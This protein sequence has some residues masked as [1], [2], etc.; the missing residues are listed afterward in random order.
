MIAVETN[1]FSLTV[2]RVAAGGNTGD[3]KYFYSFSP[4]I[5]LVREACL[6][7]FKLSNDSSEGIKIAGVV[8][9]A[10]HKQMGKCDVDE[11]GKRATLEDHV[12]APALISLAVLV[13]DDES[14]TK[15]FIV[16]DPQVINVP[17]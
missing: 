13:T 17:D 14:K 11:D 16:C 7:R 10:A 5:I 2:V 6:I 3:G 15:K 12:I 8:S 9:D 1:E 4:T